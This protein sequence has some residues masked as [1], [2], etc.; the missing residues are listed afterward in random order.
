MTYKVD[1]NIEFAFEADVSTSDHTLIESYTPLNNLPF[2]VALNGKIFEVNSNNTYSSHIYQALTL[3][4]KSEWYQALATLSQKVLSASLIRFFSWFET[5]EINENNMYSVFKDYETYQVNVRGLKP[6]STGL[7]YLLYLMK[8]GVA[9]ID[10]ER[11]LHTYIEALLLRTNISKYEPPISETL[12]NFFG[13][14]TWLRKAMGNEEYLKLESPK[15]LSSSFSIS[16]ATI[17]NYILKI[18]KEAKFKLGDHEFVNDSDTLSARAHRQFYCGNLL[19]KLGQFNENY[20][21]NDPLTELMILDFV[22]KKNIEKLKHLWRRRQFDPTTYYSYKLNGRQVFSISNIFAQNAWN[23]PSDLEQVLFSWLCAWQAIQPHNI[24]KLKKNNFVVTH[25][26]V[27]RGVFVQ[28]SY[29]KGRSRKIQE[30]PMLDARQIEGSAIIAYLEYFHDNETH[31]INDKFKATIPLT[32]GS[33]SLTERL[34]NL[35]NTPSINKEIMANLWE[36]K[37]SP[38]FLK[39]MLALHEKREYTF[40]KWVNRLKKRNGQKIGFTVEAYSKDVEFPLPAQLFGLNAIKNSAVHASSDKYREGDL[41]NQN[42]HTS[43]TEKISYLTDANKDWMNQNGRITRLVLHDIERHVYKPNVNQAINDA[44]EIALRTR[45]IKVLSDGIT[46]SGNIQIN[47]M[48]QIRCSNETLL[49]LNAEPDEIIVLDTVETVV[50][51][52]HYINEA[53]AK[54]HVLIHNALTYFERTVLPNVEWMEYLLTSKL[55]PSTVK[56]GSVQFENLKQILPPLFLNE[57]R[58]N[59]DS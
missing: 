31:L 39:A 34:I 50:T 37:S 17:L 24:P 51:M 45:V 30:P 38:I 41:I 7:N 11:G 16:I 20:V 53:Q 35:I 2:R 44:Y 40:S 13:S 29:Y 58:G 14:I 6:Q 43:L 26:N 49:E 46:D 12:T 57:I 10:Y 9:E 33:N 28:C 47:Q 1:P 48:G 21:A 55:S 4:L 59:L 18:K 42:S 23:Y 19:S 8:N 56:K 27:G 25:N 52:L 32:F 5:I 3:G 54:K 22:P 15:R 36:R